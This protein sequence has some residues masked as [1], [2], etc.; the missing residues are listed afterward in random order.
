MLCEC[1]PTLSLD[2]QM[3]VSHLFFFFLSTV[4]EISQIFLFSQRSLHMIF[5]FYV[6][7]VNCFFYDCKLIVPAMRHW[8]KPEHQR[9]CRLPCKWL[10]CWGFPTRMVYLD[11]MSCLR[12]TSLVGNPRKMSFPHFCVKTLRRVKYLPHTL[13]MNNDKNK[14]ENYHE[15]LVCS[16][17]IPNSTFMQ[18]TE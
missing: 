6:S 4:S 2:L 5:S 17:S 14:R 8:D 10:I 12:Y 16:C 1:L 7:W 9:Y 18:H 15:C 11:Y 13:L 3:V